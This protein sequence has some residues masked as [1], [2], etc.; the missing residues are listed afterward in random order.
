MR[1]QSLSSFV[2]L[3]SSVTSKSKIWSCMTRQIQ[4]WST[5]FVLQSKKVKIIGHAKTALTSLQSEVLSTHRIK[6]KDLRLQQ[7]SLRIN[8]FLI[9]PW[10]LKEHS[11]KP[12]SSAIWLIVFW[13]LA[14]VE[15]LKMTEI[16]ME[17]KGS[18]W[19]A[20]SFP[21]S[22][23]SYS[24]NSS[25][26]WSNTLRGT[27]RWTSKNRTCNRQWDQSRLREDWSRLCQQVTGVETR[28]IMSWR[29]ECRR[30]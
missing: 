22:T 10:L 4:T 8:S 19:L 2:H 3:I 15:P 7:V 30:F 5:C 13:Q 9:S 23:G 17:R 14:W 12:T 20:H 25:K 16:T 24:D 6:G 11:R 18:K 29:L 26:R 28:T 1:S 21:L 27:L